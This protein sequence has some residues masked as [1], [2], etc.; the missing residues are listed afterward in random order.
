VRL[1][2]DHHSGR[3]RK[4]RHRSAGDQG[5]D[6]RRI[7]SCLRPLQH[8]PPRPTVRL[9]LGSHRCQYPLLR[10]SE[11]LP[12]ERCAQTARGLGPHLTGSHT[13]QM[14]PPSRFSAWPRMTADRSEESQKRSY[15]GFSSVLYDTSLPDHGPLFPN[16]FQNHRPDFWID[17]RVLEQ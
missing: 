3:T 4:V 15:S 1:G 10:M 5:P 6:E 16:P 14:R 9:S 2:H 7:R 12:E 17:Q 11:V 13:G 8:T